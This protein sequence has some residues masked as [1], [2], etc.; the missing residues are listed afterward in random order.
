V[1]DKEPALTHLLVSPARRQ[2]GMSLIEVLVGVAIMMII[3]MGLI[4]LFSRSIR[5]NREGANFTDL[6]NVARTTL[7]EYVRYD[8]NAPQLTLA[9]GKVDLTVQQYYDT[10]SAQW[11]AIPAT[12]P[13]TARFQRTIVVEQFTAGDLTDN[14]SLDDPL[15]GGV[16]KDAVQVKRIRVLVRPLWKFEAAFGRPTP[17]QVETLKAI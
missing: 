13:Y 2:R 10:T 9:P 1:I 7:E 15:D 3:A 4:P 14:G 17:V 6:T 12:I 8:F 16:T 5:Q 11:V